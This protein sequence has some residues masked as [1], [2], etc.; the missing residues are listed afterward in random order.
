MSRP[1]TA[2]FQEWRSGHPDLLNTGKELMEEAQILMASGDAISTAAM[3][4]ARRFRAWN[5]QLTSSPSNPVTALM[6]KLTAKTDG[7]WSD[8]EA[9]LKIEVFGFI[10]KA[11]ANLK[12]QEGGVEGKG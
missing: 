7:A 2:S 3:D 4:F 5:K 8:R 10:E 9:L 1:W 6:P 11:I 12:A